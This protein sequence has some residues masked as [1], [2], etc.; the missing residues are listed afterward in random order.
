MFKYDRTDKNML[1]KYNISAG[2]APNQC[3]VPSN[4]RQKWKSNLN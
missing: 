3:R 2:R 4:L 1:Q